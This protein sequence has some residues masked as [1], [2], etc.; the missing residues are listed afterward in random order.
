MSWLSEFVNRLFPPRGT[1]QPS[2][3]ENLDPDNSVVDL[4][5]SKGRDSSFEARRKLAGDY[6]RS[7]Y[8]G[9]TEEN[10]WLHGEIKRRS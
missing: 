5:K 8:S 10:I 4:L 6:G 3:D 7:A 9:T 2:T 1:D